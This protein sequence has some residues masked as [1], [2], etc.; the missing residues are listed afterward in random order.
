MDPKDKNKLDESESMY[1][2]L[3]TSKEGND[4]VDKRETFEMEIEADESNKYPREILNNRLEFYAALF[5]QSLTMQMFTALAFST[6]MSNL[7][8]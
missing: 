8:K 7:G 2:E 5:S 6:V 1:P 3:P 4:E